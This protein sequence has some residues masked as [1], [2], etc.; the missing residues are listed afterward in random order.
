MQKDVQ[1]ALMGQE[2]PVNDSMGVTLWVST[3]I[4]IQEA[5]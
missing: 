1:A 2:S 3:G 4:K 5:Q